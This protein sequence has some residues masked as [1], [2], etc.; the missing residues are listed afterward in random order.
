MF[1]YF[2]EVIFLSIFLKL[3]IILKRIFLRKRIVKN[4]FKIFNNQIAGHSP[5]KSE[6]NKILKK[7]TKMLVSDDEKYVYKPELVYKTVEHGYWKEEFFYKNQIN[8][9]NE[10]KNFIPIYY[11]S[12]KIMNDDN[13]ELNYL[14]LENLTYNFDIPCIIDLQ[15][16]KYRLSKGSSKEKEELE[17]RKHPYL[18]KIGF[19]IDALK[20]WNEKE[21]N[22]EHFSADY[23]SKL[24][25]IT[26][27]DGITNFFFNGIE[28]RKDVIQIF[29]KKLKEFINVFENQKELE[30]KS[31]SLLLIYEGK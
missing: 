11:E 13:I 23:V 16:G 3:V 1:H 7:I 30:F 19:K 18:H 5:D 17:L 29:S 20:K 4:K 27:K 22:F 12:V 8:K 26:I 10:M 9:I 28:I 24:T 21:K 14:K 6:R 2:N 25:D 31:S 15:I